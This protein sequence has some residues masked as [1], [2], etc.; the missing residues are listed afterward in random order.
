MEDHS[1]VPPG[2]PDLPAG[3]SYRKLGPG[4]RFVE[5][6]QLQEET[7]QRMERAAVASSGVA[8]PAPLPEW[9]VKRPAS[10][11]ARRRAVSIRG[12]HFWITSRTQIVEIRRPI[13]VVAPTRRSADP[14]W[15]RFH[16]RE[17]SPSITF[18]RRYRGTRGCRPLMRDGA[19]EDPATASSG[20]QAFNRGGENG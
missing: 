9:T 17:V 12:P 14:V 10:L 1:Q 16:R 13:Q 18:C 11:V 3:R 20:F 7:D 5:E 2:Q 4:H 8:T 6:C 19:P 15:P